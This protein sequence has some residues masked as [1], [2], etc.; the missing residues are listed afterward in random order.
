MPFRTFQAYVE[1]KAP[2]AVLQSGQTQGKVTVYCRLSE[3]DVEILSGTTGY[4]RI[5]RGSRSLGMVLWR[6][7]LRYLRT[8]FW[9]W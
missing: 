1:R 8:E 3:P 6:K 4:A 5:Y 9:L 7:A 2:S